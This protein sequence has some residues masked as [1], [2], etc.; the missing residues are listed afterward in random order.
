VSGALDPNWTATANSHWGVWA[1][2][3]CGNKL[4][5]GGDFTEVSGVAQLHFAQFSDDIDQSPSC[6][7]GGP[8]GGADKPRVKRLKAKVRGNRAI[9]RGRLVPP[10]PGDKVGLVFYA[11]GSPLRR[12][13][14]KSDDLNADSRFKK[15]FKVPAG[16]TRCKVKV[17]Y[18]GDTVGRKKFK[19]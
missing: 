16:S 12:V 15:K 2:F 5:I 6:I 8:G 19:C 9:I 7:A 11:N 10:A 4:Y 17:A 14:K 18:K 3:A 1:T 13:D